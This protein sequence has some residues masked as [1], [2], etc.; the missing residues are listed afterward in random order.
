[1]WL[2]S[3]SSS[4]SSNRRCSILTVSHKSSILEGC[5]TKLDAT[6]SYRPEAIE[7]YLRTALT[8]ALI[9]PTSGSSLCT[10]ATK[11]T[12]LFRFLSIMALFA[13]SQQTSPYQLYTPS[14]RLQPKFNALPGAVNTIIS[15]A[16]IPET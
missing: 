15:E 9:Q 6:L 3:S 16:R 10:T 7:R 4:S 13:S 1:M 14:S 8:C 5:K 12:H 11:H 2:S